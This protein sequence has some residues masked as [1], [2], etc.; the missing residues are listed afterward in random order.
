MPPLP[1]EERLLTVFADVHYYFSPPSPRPLLH[2]FD[3][4]SYLYVY[5]DATQNTA[6][7]EIANNPGF[8]EQD[9]FAGSL[10]T[11]LL[12]NSDK[13]PT[14]FTLTVNTQRQSTSTESPSNEWSLPSGH[15]QDH[16]GALH[17]LHTLDIYFWTLEDA[18]LFL[19]TAQQILSPSQVDIIAAQPPA[20]TSPVSTVVQQ[21]ENVA[22]SD[23][24][25]QNSYQGRGTT[26][27]MTLPPP[28]P[29][30]APPT[31]STMPLTPPATQPQ[32]A[33]VAVLGKT[34]QQ[35]Q[36]KHQEQQAENYTPLAY[37]PAAPAAPEPIQH[38]EKTPPPADGA[39]GNGLAAVA[40]RDQAAYAAAPHPFGFS[41]PPQGGHSQVQDYRH[42]HERQSPYVSPPLTAGLIAPTAISPP[43]SQGGSRS[44]APPPS[45]PPP[46][47]Q[48]GVLGYTPQPPPKEPIP[49]VYRQQTFGAPP[50][51]DTYN[52]NQKQI[53][54]Q[55]TP[56]YGQPPQQL[57]PGSP[58]GQQQ[59]YSPQTQAQTQALQ[60]QQQQQPP[61][62]PP[63]G[64]YSDYSY[65]QP[66][67]APT[68][69]YDIHNQ[70]YR[71]TENEHRHHQR[72]GSGSFTPTDKKTGK[73]TENAIRVEKGVNR[74]LKKLEKKL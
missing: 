42:A 53:Q 2:R 66:Q 26:D 62:P 65:K 46:T 15:P 11:A 40:A 47:A 29:S 31:H 39:T 33:P 55:A 61:P 58:Y 13:F 70:V 63:I 38:R 18:R 41:G 52:Q 22:I 14:L 71:P 51:P 36:T 34:V 28:P 30:S 24:G 67:A 16:S 73:I 50:T 54:Q 5:H 57:P 69:V 17:R 23:P 32:A 27:P 3:K 44:F 10:G 4:G 59:Q 43:P 7:V 49:G 9:A 68:N 74:F 56:N 25:Y 35:P 20:H 19:S 60:Q 37:N 1:G 45:A 64:G 6:R 48:I 8:P 21:L 72:R 12:R